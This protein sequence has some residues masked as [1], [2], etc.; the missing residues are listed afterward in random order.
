MSTI[1]EVRVAEESV[2]NAL[3]ALRKADKQDQ[4]LK[5]R[6]IAALRNATDDHAKAV[7]ELKSDLPR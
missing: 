3:E 7:R 4:N 1:E 5:D 6:L 2:K